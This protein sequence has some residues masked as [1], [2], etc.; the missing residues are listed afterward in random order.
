MICE[1]CLKKLFPNKKKNKDVFIGKGFRL[2]DI[3]KKI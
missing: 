2:D 1:K 3:K